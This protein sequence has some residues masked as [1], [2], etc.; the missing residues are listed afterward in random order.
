M[1][2]DHLVKESKKWVE[3]AIIS[4]GQ[5]EQLLE[6]YPKKQNKPVLLTF[7]ALFIGLAFLTFVASNWSYLTDL[8]RMV[9]LLASLTAFYLSG[10][11][12]YRK[13]SKRVGT[14]LI[15]IALLI[16]GSSIF[17]VGQMYHYTSYSAFPFFL[18]SIVAF[19]LFLIFKDDSFFYATLVIM[20]VGQLYS[21]LV[22][23]HFHIWLALLFI[24]GLGWFVL[25]SR[26]V[27]Q[28]AA[29][30]VSY[31]LH[32]VILVFSEGMPYYWL[33]AFFLLLYV[34][35]DFLLEKGNV[36]VFKTLSILSVFTMLVLQV[37]FLGN[38]YVGELTETSLYFFLAWAILFFFSVV[39]SAMSST[40]YYWIDLLLFVPVFRFESGDMLS[41]L[42]LFLYALLWLISGYQQE[43]SRW[44]NKGTIAFLLTTFIAYFQ[45]AWDF[46]DRS[47]F[48]LI[49]GALLFALSYFL[50]K[51]RRT[52]HKGGEE[53]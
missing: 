37:F 2:R 6:R 16:F 21:G 13:K 1:N 19:G 27:T 3:N 18:W 14:S 46:M 17:L 35:E 32:A 40:N 20:T 28:L 47:L 49:G 22:F 11:W 42:I 45:L 4:E 41:L 48:F 29:F 31:T 53:K 52:I 12:V 26:K 34:V 10:D 30:G 8:G 15:L 43:V 23:Q 39:R 24:L 25:S 36:R 7:A 44:V 51:K 50:E 38:E 33:I 5:R 9:I